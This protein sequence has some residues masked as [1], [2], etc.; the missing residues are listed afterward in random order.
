MLQV[1][2]AACQ[3]APDCSRGTIVLE[4]TFGPGEFQQA[5]HEFEQIDARTYAQSYAATKGVVAARINGNPQGPYPVN[6]DGVPLD[7]VRDTNN[8]PLP[9]N[10]AKMQPARYRLDVPVCQ[11][12]R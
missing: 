8:Q 1:V 6:E 5:F 7:Q 9:A 12:L 3:I 2:E 11:P 10:H 4:S